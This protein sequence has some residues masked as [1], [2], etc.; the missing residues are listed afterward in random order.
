[1]KLRFGVNLTTKSHKYSLR[2][3]WKKLNMVSSVTIQIFFTSQKQLPFQ[4]LPTSLVLNNKSS[5]NNFIFLLQYRTLSNYI[6]INYRRQSHGCIIFK[7]GLFIYPLSY[8]L[9]NVC[10]VMCVMQSDGQCLTLT[11]S[12][13]SFLTMVYCLKWCNVYKVC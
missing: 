9:E 4:Y 2:C 7:H 11:V 6:S 3:E 8:W 12:L 1:M 10:C 13:I 5:W